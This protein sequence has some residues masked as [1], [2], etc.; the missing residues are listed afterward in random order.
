MDTAKRVMMHGSGFD[1]RGFS[2]GVCE[3][4]T[5]IVRK[6]VEAAAKWSRFRRDTR[7]LYNMSDHLLRDI[8]L[9][10]EEVAQWNRIRFL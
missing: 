7:A 10:R 2:E 9:R 3:R 1:V 5:R 8:G 4:L 6:P